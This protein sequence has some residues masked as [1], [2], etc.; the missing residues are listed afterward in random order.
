[1]DEFELGDIFRQEQGSAPGIPGG[2]PRDVGRD[3]L[4]GLHPL[5]EAGDEWRQIGRPIEERGFEGDGAEERDAG[6]E[7]KKGDEGAPQERLL[8]A[9]AAREQEKEG[10][11]VKNHDRQEENVKLID[12]DGA[13]DSEDAHPGRGS[14][15]HEEHSPA[16]L[17]GLPAL[18]DVEKNSEEKRGGHHAP[19]EV[20]EQAAG[21]RQS[22]GCRIDQEVTGL[23]TQDRLKVGEQRQRVGL[24]LAVQFVEREAEWIAQGPPVVPGPGQQGQDV[25]HWGG[26]GD[27]PARTD[28][29]HGVKPES[30]EDPQTQTVAQG[31]EAKEQRGGQDHD[32]RFRPAPCL[33]GFEG[34][35]QGKESARKKEKHGH[36]RQARKGEPPN[37]VACD[38]KPE[39]DQ[40][41][42]PVEQPSA[43]QVGEGE[44]T[45]EE[46]EGDCGDGALGRD[47]GLVGAGGERLAASPQDDGIDQR[48]KGS[49]AGLRKGGCNGSG[50]REHKMQGE[51]PRIKGGESLAGGQL[52]PN[53]RLVHGLGHGKAVELVGEPHGGEQS[54][55]H[56]DDEAA[57][58]DHGPA[59]FEG[60]EQSLQA[61]FE[62]HKI[63]R[64]QA[65]GAR[66]VSGGGCVG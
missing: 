45:D 46:E 30:G 13:I 43:E 24:R 31:H 66:A 47:N 12:R 48:A 40:G 29:G 11:S 21:L 22:L 52:A 3:G 5:A 18:E 35:R 36:L 28:H 59:L 15:P 7:K 53:L 9:E 23:E 61:D 64:R 54:D 4:A 58:P 2:G 42:G 62:A 25:D 63:S 55:D 60:V 10:E 14:E 38:D 32:D 37:Q 8:E 39:T 57:Q 50:P 19:A 44:R 17:C 56:G 27:E 34:P 20:G 49:L 41:Q 51:G 65:A 1:M 16:E 6:D 26:K 33:V